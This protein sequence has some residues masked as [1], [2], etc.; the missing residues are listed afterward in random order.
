MP[1]KFYDENRKSRADRRKPTPEEIEAAKAAR[2]AYFREYRRKN[3]D[4]VRDAALRYWAKKSAQE[5]QKQEP[6][7]SREQS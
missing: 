2:N 3:K 1:E 6:T 4:K 7:P 5:R